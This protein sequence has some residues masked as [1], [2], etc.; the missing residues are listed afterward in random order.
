MRPPP[1]L[2]PRE[3]LAGRRVEPVQVALEVA[4]HERVAR[5]RRRS[6]RA[7]QHGV[8]G[9]DRRA[10][11]PLERDDRA[12]GR[13]D[14]ERV[15]VRGEPAIARHVAAPPDLARIAREHRD[16]PLVADDEDIV[17]EDAHRRVDV[18]QALDLGLAMRGRD[19]RGPE[20]LAGRQR[21]RDDLAVVEAGKH[22]VAV[23]DRRAI[24]AQREPGHRLLIDPGLAA[25][26]DAQAPQASV[27]RAHDDDAGRNG[28]RRENLAAGRDLPALGAGLGVERDELAARAADH[29]DAFADGRAARELDVDG[30]PP[31]VPAGRE[32]ERAHVAAMSRHVDALALHGRLQ[33][34]AQH[35][36]AALGAGA[37]DLVDPHRGDRNPRVPQAARRP[38]PCRRPQP[39]TR[40]PPMPGN[41]SSS[42]PT[43][44]ALP[45]SIRRS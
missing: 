5:E 22:H 15:A 8:L 40:S 23:D 4:D 2:P 13:R 26:R 21:E 11:A 33:P 17:A 38:F 34:E 32:L 31:D 35:V 28:R 10:V 18:H 37:P 39:A 29:D 43:P 3:K 25:V 16:A 7:A 20:Q 36:V 14:I 24:A 9:P 27:H 41:A 19:G 45:R 42:C 6:Q 44:P 30:G 1:V 12:V